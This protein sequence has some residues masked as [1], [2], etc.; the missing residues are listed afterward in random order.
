MRTWHQISKPEPFGPGFE[1]RE[2]AEAHAGQ[3]DSNPLVCSKIN[4]GNLSFKVEVAS[5]NML[6]MTGEK[7]VDTKDF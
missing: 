5:V 2:K 4:M 6:C 3:R 7:Y 1:Y